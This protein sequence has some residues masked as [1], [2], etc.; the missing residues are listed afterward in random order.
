[1]SG[2]REQDLSGRW[3]GIFNYPAQ[4]P[5]NAFEAVLRDTGGLLTGIIT[6]PREFFEPE[7]P[8]HQAVID[9]RRD[10]ANVSW[11]K[12]YDDLSRPTPH[13][14]G[15][16]QP[17]GDEIVGEWTIP[18]DWSGTF[19]MVRASGSEEAVEREVGETV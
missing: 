10:G 1:M 19:M 17:G 6:Q 3:S 16:I 18:G 5:P 12:V 7:G 15:T 13:Y 14:S 11:I 9:G 4:F 2:S 8:P